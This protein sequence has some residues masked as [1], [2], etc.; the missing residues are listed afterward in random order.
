MKIEGIERKDKKPEREPDEVDRI[1]K[2]PLCF[3]C[4]QERVLVKLLP[5]RKVE[6]RVCVNPRCFKFTNLENLQSW[7]T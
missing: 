2:H 5:H 3:N 7:T 1:A 6:M 4:K